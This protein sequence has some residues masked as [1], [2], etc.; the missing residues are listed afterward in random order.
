MCAY[1]YQPS[2]GFEITNHSLIIALFFFL[3]YGIYIECVCV[4][5]IN[6]IVCN[7]SD[8]LYI[9][10]IYICNIYG[11]QILGLGNISWVQI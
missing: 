5:C 7:L 8:I 4:C 6:L 11:W 10:V 2:S 3:Y 1:V 9:L